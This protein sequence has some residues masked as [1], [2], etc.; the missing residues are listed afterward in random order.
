MGEVPLFGLM[1]LNI[2]EKM[3]IGRK[4]NKFAELP[5]MERGFLLKVVKSIL[6]LFSIFRKMVQN[7][8]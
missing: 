5:S 1:V 2:R 7:L 3:F 6:R 4:G 8:E